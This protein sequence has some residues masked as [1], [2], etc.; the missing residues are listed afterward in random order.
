MK[1]FMSFMTGAI[2]GG[3]IGASVVM[4]YAPTDGKTM[5]TRIKDSFIELKSDVLQAAEDRRKELNEQLNQ[6]RMS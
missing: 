6:L 2:L 4:L 5:Q 3:L 1:K